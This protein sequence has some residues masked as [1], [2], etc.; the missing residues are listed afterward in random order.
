MLD[1][2]QI[3][4]SLSDSI[5]NKDN[6]FGF[7]LGTVMTDDEVS[8]TYKYLMP[9]GRTTCFDPNNLCVAV[10]VVNDKSA[11]SNFTTIYTTD[12][13]NI[14]SANNQLSSNDTPTIYP[15][16]RLMAGVADGPYNIPKQGSQVFLAVSSWYDPFIIQYSDIIS[17]NMSSLSPDGTMSIVQDWDYTGFNTLIKNLDP[18]GNLLKSSEMTQGIDGIGF[19]L[20]NPSGNYTYLRMNQDQITMSVDQDSSDFIQTKTVFTMKNTTEDLGKL[21]NDFIT[22]TQD[23]VSEVKT[24]NTLLGGSGS[25]PYLSASPG[26]PCTVSPAAAP[27]FATATSNLATYLSNI[28]DISSRLP[29]IL[30]TG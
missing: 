17:Y 18:T 27:Q 3:I 10:K 22:L 11:D 24:L 21:L 13:N 2:K 1:W 14:A 8:D 16:V 5:K 26:S 23:L 25:A 30:T 12:S 9:S 20:Q 19:E 15:T 4:S 28:N 6:N 29:N 7:Y